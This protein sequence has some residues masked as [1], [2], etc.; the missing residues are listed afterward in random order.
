[1]QLPSEWAVGMVGEA[2]ATWGAFRRD[3]SA[4]ILSGASLVIPP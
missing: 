1:M 3:G 4:F 2:G